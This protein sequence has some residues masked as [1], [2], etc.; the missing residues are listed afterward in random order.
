MEVKTL[1]NNYAYSEVLD[2]ID[3]MEVK[4]KGMLPKK[5]IDF[6]NEN[7][8][9]EYQKHVDPQI[10]LGQQNISKE[11]ITILAMIN[12]KYWVKDEKHKVELTD[13][14]R[15]NNKE[16]NNNE[17]NRILESSNNTY[18]TQNEYKQDD[19]S[20]SLIVKKYGFME[21]INNWFRKF[22]KKCD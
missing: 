9:F 20:K 17:L 18:T 15:E 22:R 8:D 5:L 1:K 7:R 11:A 14:Y 3:N 4:Y 13:K 19:E 16:I 10:P 21:R 2:I 12:L 6:L